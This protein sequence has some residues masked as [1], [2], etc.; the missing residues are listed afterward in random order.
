MEKL[1]NKNP[2]KTPEGYFEDISKGLTKRLSEKGIDIPENEGFIVPNSYFED[3]HENILKKLDAEEAKVIQLHPYKKL[4]YAA[5]S[6][7]AVAMVVL[8]LNQNTSK[9]ITFEDIAN[10]DI[11]NYFE[12][13]DLDFSTYEIAEVV[14]VDDLEIGDILSNELNQDMILNYLDNNTEN[15]EELNMDYDE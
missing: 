13:N 11:E 12:D 8:F 2:F 6:I 15:F 1:N 10:S 5:A 3:V 9:A 7:A 14:P 4:Y